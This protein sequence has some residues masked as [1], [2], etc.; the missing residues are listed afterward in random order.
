MLDSSAES[1]S[2]APILLYNSAE[3]DL[4]QAVV[5]QLNAAAPPEPAAAEKPAATK[6][7]N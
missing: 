1:L 7:K 3:S 2:K 6:D 5:E 4:T